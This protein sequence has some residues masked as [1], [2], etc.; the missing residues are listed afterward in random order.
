MN[1]MKHFKLV[2]V[3]TNFIEETDEFYI[4]RKCA[5]DREYRVLFSYRM[6]IANSCF[7]SSRWME[8]PPFVWTQYA[9]ICNKGC[10][11]VKYRKN[12]LEIIQA[13]HKLAGIDGVSFLLEELNEQIQSKKISGR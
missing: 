12:I 8:Y 6:H 10:T 3:P 13:S 11:P 5:T 1:K 7:D 4:L 2:K 9:A